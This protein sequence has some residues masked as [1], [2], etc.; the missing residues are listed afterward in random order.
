VYHVMARGNRR[1]SIIGGDKD[2]QMFIETFAKRAAVFMSSVWKIKLVKE[3]TLRS[4][5]NIKVYRV[6]S[7]AGGIGVQSS[8]ESIS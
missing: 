5:P 2:R 6:P 8:F 1:E 3:S 7:T 4:C